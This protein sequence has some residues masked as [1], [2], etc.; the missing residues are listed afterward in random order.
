MVL[1]SVN[2]T[3]PLTFVQEQTSYS[4]LTS[5][6]SVT[7][8]IAGSNKYSCTVSFGSQNITNAQCGSSFYVVPVPN[9][10]TIILHVPGDSS[11][12]LTSYTF[13][14]G[15]SASASSSKTV[16]IAGA[17]GGAVGAI[18]LVV[19]VVLYLTKWRKRKVILGLES[20]ND[21]DPLVD[22]EL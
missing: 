20:F 11:N 1:T 8:A 17:A 12:L 16:L 4:I 15:V 21:A 9:D 7:L 14:Y 10:V 19:L 6:P 3:A 18:I 5:D 2:S 13:S 22:G